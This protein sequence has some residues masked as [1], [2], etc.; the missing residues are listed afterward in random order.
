MPVARASL[1]SGLSY[2][3]PRAAI[4][5]LEAAFGFEL[6]LLVEGPDGAVS[7]SELQFGNGSVMVG[8]E[9]SADNLSPASLGGKNTQSVHIQIETDVDA[10]C[11]RAKAAGARVFAEPEDQFYGDRVYRCL[12]PE[13]HIWTVGQTVATVTRE[14]A[15]AAIGMKITGWV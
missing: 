15:E 11:E 14:E 5:F 9:W 7:H 2:R 12:D 3:D 4:A 13:G 1:I 10:H 6:T 8:G